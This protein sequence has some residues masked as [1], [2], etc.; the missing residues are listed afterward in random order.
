MYWLHILLY[1]LRYQWDIPLFCLY[2][3]YDHG[4]VIQINWS[5][6]IIDIF[7]LV[8]VSLLNGDV[9]SV[10]RLCY[11]NRLRI[12]EQNKLKIKLIQIFNQIM[13][14]KFVYL[15][16]Q[17]VLISTTYILCWPRSRY[18]MKFDISSYKKCTSVNA[19]TTL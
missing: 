2:A 4:N 11:K 14:T 12:S 1:W 8:I 16:Y 9:L 13:P 19:F 7:H 15:F 10:L 17:R 3:L 6:H 18:C 5:I